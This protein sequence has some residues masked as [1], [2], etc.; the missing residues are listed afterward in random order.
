MY[1][2]HRF[3]QMIAD[4]VRIRAYARALEET[5]KPGMTVVDLGAGPGVLSML[6][7]RFGAAR[8]H[9]IDLSDCTSVGRELSAANGFGDRI[10]WHHADSMKVSLDQ[11][12]D[13]LVADIRGSLPFLRNNLLTLADAR[14]RLLADGGILIP[15]EDRCYAALAEAPECY[16]EATRPW[17]DNHFDFNWGPA[18]ARLAN[19]WRRYDVD[20]ELLISAPAHWCK[21]D[22][23]TLSEPDVDGRLKLT[24]ERDAVAHGFFLWFDAALTETVR[25]SGGPAGP[26]PVVYGAGFFPFPE[27]VKVAAGDPAIVDLSARLVGDDYVWV[28]RSALGGRRFRQSTFQGMPLD[29]EILRRAAHKAAKQNAASAEA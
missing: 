9:A 3:G 20:P 12:A 25:F 2:L 18:E 29:N 5:V 16:A 14:D 4:D 6:A 24:V 1:D 21:L 15:L 11:P 27:P 28:W 23:R 22:Y 7:C 19:L 8:V 10:E 13:L 26:R 17:K